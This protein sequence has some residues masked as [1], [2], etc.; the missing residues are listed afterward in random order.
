MREIKDGKFTA[1]CTHA[2]QYKRYGD[3]FYVY[4][5]TADG[6]TTDNELWEFLHNN[7]ILRREIP[8]N[9][10]NAKLGTREMDTDTYFAGWYRLTEKGNGWELTVC[11]PYAD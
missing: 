10:Y 1:V 8:E 7:D 2:G 6:E 5:I 9:I 3:T 11:S 4:T